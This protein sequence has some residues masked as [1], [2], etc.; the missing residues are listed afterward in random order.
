MPADGAPAGLAVHA[1]AVAIEGRAL[2]ITGRSGAGKSRL[3]AALVAASTPRCRILLIGDDRV[4]LV[5]SDRGLEARPHPRIAGFLERR[6]FGLVAMGWCERAMIAAL[7]TLGEDTAPFTLVRHNLPT[8]N[9]VEVREA[10]RHEA[11]LA[12]WPNLL[13]NDTFDRNEAGS[14]ATAS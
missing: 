1:T 4:L 11:V 6:G 14:R 13:A 5:G 12:W 2:L 10:F 7:A 8:I 9:L 3:A